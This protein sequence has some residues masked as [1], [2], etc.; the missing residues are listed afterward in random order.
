MV[1][2]QKIVIHIVAVNLVIRGMGRS[3]AKK[4]KK[5]EGE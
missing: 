2:E 5:G 1:F 4:V 3:V